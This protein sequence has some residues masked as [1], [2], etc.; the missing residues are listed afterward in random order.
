M[1]RHMRR[2][3][4]L[5]A[6]T[7]VDCEL[8]HGAKDDGSN[9]GVK[10]VL[11]PVSRAIAERA[12]EGRAL[13]KKCITVPENGCCPCKIHRELLYSPSTRIRRRRGFSAA[14][15]DTADTK[16]PAADNNL[17][18]EPKE[19][20]DKGDDDEADDEDE[21]SPSVLFPLL[22]VAIRSRAPA[23]QT[24]RPSRKLLKL[25]DEKVLHVPVESA[26]LGH[27]ATAL[28]SPSSGA[29][30]HK[31]YKFMR[32]I[33]KELYNDVGKHFNWPRPN[34][35]NGA[36]AIAAGVPL[37][38]S[39][40]R[41]AVHTL[42]E[43]LELTA[44]APIVLS[45]LALHHRSNDLSI[46]GACSD[47]AWESDVNARARAPCRALVRVTWRRDRHAHHRDGA[48]GRSAAARRHSHS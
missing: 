18:A 12:A 6:K 10:L 30:A 9:L 48:G 4:E 2:L 13:R 31:R 34:V 38:T 27:V 39:N 3:L 22:T 46:T 33:M 17:D 1:M 23:L 42:L 41:L 7:P 28:L 21:S 5:C 35:I 24:P 45:L 15:A 47:R 43:V 29:N 36:L 37:T 26:V 11:E 20:A 8:L 44:V 14:A 40:L 25:I 32:A 19:G 16:V